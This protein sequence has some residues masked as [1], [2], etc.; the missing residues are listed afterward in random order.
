[1]N[2]LHRFIRICPAHVPDGPR[3][4]KHELEHFRGSRQ[5]LR[6][7]VD[8]SSEH[9]LQKVFVEVFVIHAVDLSEHGLAFLLARL[10]HYHGDATAI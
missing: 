10:E 2:D 7:R 3:H 5:G 6:C 8:F 1:M 4:V 9:P